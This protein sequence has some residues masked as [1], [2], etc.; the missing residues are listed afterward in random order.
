[1]KKDKDRVVW[2]KLQEFN[3]NYEFNMKGQL[4]NIK[5]KRIIKPDSG[6]YKVKVLGNNVSVP[7]NELLYKYFKSEY[8]NIYIRIGYKKISGFDYLISTNGDVFSLKK[9]ITLKQYEDKE[10]YLSVSLRLGETNH[11]KKV[12]RL[13]AESFIPNP[14]NKPQVNHIS[15]VK[16]DNKHINLEW[17]TQ[18]ENMIHAVE[19]NLLSTKLSTEDVVEIKQLLNEGNLTGTKIAELYSVSRT[20]I[21]GIKNGRTWKTI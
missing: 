18:E 19:N 21:Y 12:H 9:F 2:T 5:S 13:V 17:A 6:R 10:G 3:F 15:G 11:F 8:L 14:K 4:R 16:Q 1:M 20:T 7:V